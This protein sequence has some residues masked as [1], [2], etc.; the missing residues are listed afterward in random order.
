MYA[1]VND[2]TPSRA[3]VVSLH[4]TKLDAQDALEAYEEH[5]AEHPS[6][7][8]SGGYHQMAS[9]VARIIPVDDDV[10][11]GDRVPMTTETK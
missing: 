6:L 10:E 3:T 4:A 5:E 8:A 1:V 11:V 2:M 7:N 9:R